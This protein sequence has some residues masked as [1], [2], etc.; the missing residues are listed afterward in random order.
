MQD[1]RRPPESAWS[2]EAVLCGI[3]VDPARGGR[4]RQ[5]Y[6]PTGSARPWTAEHEPT[7]D[8]PVDGHLSARARR[9]SR[10][11]GEWLMVSLDGGGQRLMII[12]LTSLEMDDWRGRID[13]NV[14]W[15]A[16]RGTFEVVVVEGPRKGMR[17]QATMDGN[18]LHGVRAF[19]W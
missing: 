17:A 12:V 15:P 18:Q 4:R 7:L 11:V 16:M 14:P 3:T 2:G 6:R 13:G 5:I 9:L 1:R 10:V 8:R 19:R